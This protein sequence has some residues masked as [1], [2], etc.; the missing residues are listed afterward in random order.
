MILMQ[1]LL[2][3]ISMSSK[4]WKVVIEGELGKNFAPLGHV[5]H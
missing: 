5:E 1:M 4:I 2:G 3:W